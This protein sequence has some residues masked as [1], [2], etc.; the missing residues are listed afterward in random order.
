MSTASTRALLNTFTPLPIANYLIAY[1]TY[2][3]TS[4]LH[5]SDVRGECARYHSTSTYV[6]G[7]SAVS[8]YLNPIHPLHQIFHSKPSYT[9]TSTSIVRLINI[10]TEYSYETLEFL[11]EAPQSR[12]CPERGLARV[13]HP[14]MRLGHNTNSH[15]TEAAK[16]GKTRSDIE[17]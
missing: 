10:A 5:F 15:V 12:P 9:M 17:G 14:A 11:K 8:N 16:A 3:D 2:A 4:N 13:F 1:S 7:Q 6:Y